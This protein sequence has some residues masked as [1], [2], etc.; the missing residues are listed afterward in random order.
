VA[1]ADWRDCA[2]GREGY[3]TMITKCCWECQTGR[4]S[5][6]G[7]GEQLIY[8]VLACHQPVSSRPG[9]PGVGESPGMRYYC[10]M[11]GSLRPLTA[12]QVWVSRTGPSH[13]G[14]RWSR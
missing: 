8:P 10:G 6:M 13:T 12:W 11:P 4:C 9:I 5:D 2:P 3:P 1:N 7:L 14:Q